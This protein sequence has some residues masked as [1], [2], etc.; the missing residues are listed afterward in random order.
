[1]VSWVE[2]V[3]PIDYLKHNKFQ[4]DSEINPNSATKLEFPKLKKKDLFFRQKKKHAEKVHLIPEEPGTSPSSKRGD[5]SLMH[6]VSIHFN[7][8]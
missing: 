5:A 3:S 2:K 1:M 7:K 4:I 6:S 8:L